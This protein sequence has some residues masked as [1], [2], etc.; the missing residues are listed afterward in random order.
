MANDNGYAGINMARDDGSYNNEVYENTACGNENTDIRTCGSQCYG[1]HG[2]DNT[3]NSCYNYNDTGTTCC[4]HKCGVCVGAT[5]DFE[6]G[7]TVTESCTL[8]GDMSC[9]A[10]SY[11]LVM[12]A[13]D[14]VVDGAGYTLNGTVAGTDCNPWDTGESYPAPHCGIVNFANKN[15]VVI[16]DLQIKN[17]CTG[18][19]LGRVPGAGN[20]DNNT[21]TGCK[22]H[23]CG[24]S[25]TST[26]GIHIVGANNCTITNNEIHN[27]NGSGA[28]GGCSGGGN[29]VFLYGVNSDRGNHNTIDGNELHD[30][31]KSGFFMKM[32]PQHNI[33]SN[34]IATRN[35]QGGIVLRCMMSNYNIIEGNTASENSWHGIYIGGKNNTL[36]SNIVTSNNEHG[37]DMGRDDG[38]YNNEVYANTA[39]GNI[40]ADIATCGSQCYGNH[41]DCNTCNTT[42]N[43]DDDGT[44]GCTY[45]CPGETDLTITAKYEQWVGE[46]YNVIYTIK[47]LGHSTAPESTTG[48]YIDGN[49]AKTDAVGLIGP[50][51]S[52]IKTVGP[53]TMSGSD[54][55]IWVCADKDDTVNETNETNNYLENI[56]TGV[57]LPDLVITEKS[58]A[59]IS[60]ED[61]TYNIT[62]T[63]KNIGNAG[64]DASTTAIIIDGTEAATDPVPALAPDAIHAA[65]L[66]PFTMSDESDTIRVCAD[67]E[68]VVTESNENN[69][70]KENTF[71]LPGEPD[72]VIT[73]KIELWVV[74]NTYNVTY[75]VKNIGNADANASTTFIIR[76]EVE[77]ATDS[78]GTLVEGDGYT[79]TL[80]PFTM[81]GDNDTI[82]V[83]ADKNNDVEESNEDNNCM[84]NVFEY[85][86]IGCLAD[87]GSGTLF[88]C[89]D[90]VNKSCTF[91]GDMSCPSTDGL[92]IGANSITIDGNNSVLDG[93]GCTLDAI[94]LGIYN[95]GYDDVT[96]EHLEIKGFCQGLYLNNVDRNTIEH[97]DI[98]HNGNASTTAGL[99]GITMKYVYNSTI[100]NNTVHHQIAKIDPNPGCEDSGNGMFLYKGCYNNITYNKVYNNTKG[101]IF[102]KMQPMHNNISHNDLWDNGQGGIILRCMMSNYNYIEHNNASNN[103]G[104]GMFIGARE[105]T[106]RYNTVCDNRDDGPYYQDSVGGHGYGIHLGRS[107]GSFDNYLHDNEICRNDYVDVYV[108]T[109]VT[110][111]HGVNNTCDTTDNY[112]DN[113]STG[114]T[115]PCGGGGVC[116]DVD[117]LPGVTT[118]DGRQIFMYLLHGADEYPLADTWAAD[119]DG[120]CDGITTNDG[121]HIFMHLL[122]DDPE[123]PENDQYPLNCSC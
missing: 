44:T 117:G 33:I 57:V 50:D 62:Y 119:C 27:I 60:L 16:K 63:V 88:R 81:T 91:N 101:G 121:R 97:C 24:K 83:C 17:F 102:I 20:I 93:A 46:A 19:A 29:G 74:D 41:G 64:A 5:Q 31:I 48:I 122:H 38:S 23:N 112:D 69:N 67:N 118:N 115:Y 103:Y 110:G 49:L 52:Y 65:E 13:D 15:D 61:K 85:S 90:T 87:D 78:V 36:R 75:T 7:D 109:G 9:P 37:I 72:L 40:V 34:N 47:N 123:H 98:H 80:G 18:I 100:R 12:G 8:N 45:N 79:N 4:T 14:I 26:H 28:A 105:N 76:D 114:C 113:G 22:I 56:F 2:D 96:I 3:C 84:E 21:I 71:E 43:Y 116:G 107:D 68:S 106:I 70:C 94:R 35:S 1:N 99:F 39:C 77:V 11:G 92:K 104:S 108:V 54:D 111:N 59:W 53:F 73:E 89:G 32:K 55:T 82:R 58:E 30:N 86:A 42:S 95:Q 6:C 10:G 120:L 51:I 25:T 66:G